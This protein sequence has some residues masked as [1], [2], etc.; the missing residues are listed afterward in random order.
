MKNVFS[1]PDWYDTSQGSPVFEGGTSNPM[2]EEISDKAGA[3]VK[4][5]KRYYAAWLRNQGF[6]P[7]EALKPQE[8]E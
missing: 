8:S 3:P 4:E 7:A 1:N 5:V 6:S 2:F